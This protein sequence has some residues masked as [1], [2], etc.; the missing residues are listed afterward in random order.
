MVLKKAVITF[1][2]FFFFF[3]IIFFDIFI[4]FFLI[5]AISVDSTVLNKI[6]QGLAPPPIL[7]IIDADGTEKLVLEGFILFFFPI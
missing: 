1:L 7:F 6:N 3:N 2:I 5:Q 4:F